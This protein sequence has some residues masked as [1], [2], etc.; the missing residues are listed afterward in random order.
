MKH[1]VRRGESLH[2]IAKRYGTTVHCLI[3]INP[4]IY[5]PNLI[6]P[7]QKIQIR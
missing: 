5:N 1:R 6:Y 2:K 4:H 3:R 7:G